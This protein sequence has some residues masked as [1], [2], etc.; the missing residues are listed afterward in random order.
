VV[1]GP[2]RI[3]ALTGLQVGS[4][5]DLSPNHPDDRP[6]LSPFDRVPGRHLSVA[7]HA[8]MSTTS[9]QQTEC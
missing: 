4:Y 5:A 1:P 7:A 9:T 8:T 2:S 3:D 6:D